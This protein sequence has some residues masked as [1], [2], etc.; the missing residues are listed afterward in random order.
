MPP[1]PSAA[2]Q[3]K[4]ETLRGRR[5]EAAV[6][7]DETRHRS[8]RDGIA[9]DRQELVFVSRK[10]ARVNRDLRFSQA[11]LDQVLA[12]VDDDRRSVD[13]ELSDAGKEFLGRQRDLDVA[14]AELERHPAEDAERGRLQTLVE[15][16]SEQ[17]ETSSQR[18]AMLRQIAEIHILSAV[19]AEAL[20]RISHAGFERDRVAMPSWRN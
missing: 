8:L 20:F 16:R 7:L 4:L 10:L 13:R 1:A 6:A 3:K 15:L 17:V 19:C 5:I 9:R 11:D 12:R 18:Q 2:V 14:R